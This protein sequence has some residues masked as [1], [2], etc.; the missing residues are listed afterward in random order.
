M[1]KKKIPDFEAALQELEEIVEKMEDGEISLEDSL[2][3]FE[4]GIALTRACQQALAEAEQKVQI[5]LEKNGQETVEDF[6]PED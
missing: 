1:A 2:K 4:R 6:E 5:L 3:H